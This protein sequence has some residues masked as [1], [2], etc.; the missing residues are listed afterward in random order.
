LVEV[1]A[2]AKLDEAEI[3]TKLRFTKWA[4]DMFSGPSLIPLML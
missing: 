4:G 3:N 2:N 1:E